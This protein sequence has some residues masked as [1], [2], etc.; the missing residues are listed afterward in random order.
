[1]K[2][3]TIAALVLL[4]LATVS[5]A[6]PTGPTR[7]TCIGD[8]LD[9]S[10]P[11]SPQAVHS[12]MRENREPGYRGTWEDDGKGHPRGVHKWIPGDPI[13]EKLPVSWPPKERRQE[14]HGDVPNVWV[15]DDGGIVVDDPFATEEAMS[16]QK[17][18]HD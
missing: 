10:K 16:K 4:T 14:L 18:Q 2:L 1:M 9:P 11:A 17:A 15:L 8:L 3:I 12:A 13:P 6:L 5:T 7:P